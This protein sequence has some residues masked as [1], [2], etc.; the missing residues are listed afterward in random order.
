MVSSLCLIIFN[1]KISELS[2]R[3][4]VW[5]IVPASTAFQRSI[6]IILAR[7]RPPLPPLSPPFSFPRQ[8][9]KDPQNKVRVEFEKILKLSLL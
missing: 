2:P 9:K 8:N 7:P 6:S 5:R 1:F 4:L 3:T